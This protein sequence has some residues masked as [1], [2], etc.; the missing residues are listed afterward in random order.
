MDYK[1]QALNGFQL[2]PEQIVSIFRSFY[3]NEWMGLDKFSSDT[4]LNR[5]KARLLLNFLADIGLS[6]KR[7]F[8]RT[9][10]GQ[11]VYDYDGFM[12]D[13]GTLWIFHYLIATNQYI[14]VW[15]RVLNELANTD[16]FTMEEMYPLFADLEGEISDYSLKKHIHQE[17]SSVVKTYTDLFLKN[18]N[19]LEEDYDE[20]I[21]VN[22]NQEIDDAI[23]MA[24]IHIYRERFCKGATAIDISDLTEKKNG[25]G[26]ILLMD[27]FM[28][29][30]KLESFKNKEWISIES[31][32]N[33]DQI[34]MEDGNQSLKYMREYYAGGRDHD[35]WGIP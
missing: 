22:K 33:L 20:K 18:L 13:E 35:I 14:V 26:R 16:R 29:R 28:F 24:C 11:L 32:G 19:V 9:K 6:E 30:G 2:Y 34:R 21:A 8:S 31:R 10:F 12:Q 25:V 27:E 23:V 3:E 1:I 7:K 4:G 5:R 15:N 17:I